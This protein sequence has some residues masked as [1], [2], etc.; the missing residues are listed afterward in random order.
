[1]HRGGTLVEEHIAGV[2]G[3]AF[4]R[5]YLHRPDFNGVRLAKEF[6]KFYFAK[7]TEA[8]EAQEE[9]AAG[10]DGSALA[11]PTDI[12]NSPAFLQRKLEVIKSDIAKVEEEIVA[13]KAKLEEGKAEWGHQ[14]DALEVEVSLHSEGN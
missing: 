7:E 11:S 2:P 4:I 8:E 6:V 5:D 10:D 1:M 13:A 3:D 9:T 14:F 12:L